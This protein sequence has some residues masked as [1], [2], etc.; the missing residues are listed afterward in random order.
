MGERRGKTSD[1]REI[2]LTEGHRYF[3]IDGARRVEKIGLSKLLKSN[4]L[5]EDL[6]WASEQ[7]KDDGS[8]IHEWAEIMLTG[9]LGD[10]EPPPPEVRRK[11]D[12]IQLWM[13][14]V[15]AR[16]IECETPRYI[17]PCDACCTPDLILK[18]PHTP[19][20]AAGIYVVELK[21]GQSHKHY[22]FQTAGQALSW[23]PVDPPP[24]GALFLDGESTLPKFEVHDDP[25]DIDVV[26]AA[27]TVHHGRRRAGLEIPD[28]PVE[29]T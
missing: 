9:R 14:A 25:S 17:Q 16:V 7:A 13:K 11:L 2:L 10:F 24:R 19:S 22:R 6:R 28:Y 18:L 29:S 26:I 23:D 5:Q 8:A 4:G 20:F 15:G 21:N 3:I 12:Q 27:A 1:G